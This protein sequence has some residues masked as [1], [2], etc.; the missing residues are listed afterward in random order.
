MS[1]NPSIAAYGWSPVPSDLKTLL[2]NHSE[3]SSPAPTYEISS[4]TP[5]DTK[6][7]KAVF[8]YAKKELPRET[9]HHSM[10]VWYYGM[11]SFL[12]INPKSQ[13]QTNIRKEQKANQ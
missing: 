4:L 7:A 1:S 13:F 9:L 8:E 10:R 6:L 2:K 11:S 3:S 12:N 5:P